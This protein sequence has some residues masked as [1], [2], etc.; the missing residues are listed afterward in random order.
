MKIIS[1]SSLDAA[2]WILFAVFTKVKKW[3]WQVLKI[4]SFS[5][6]ERSTELAVYYLA[7]ARYLHFDQIHTDFVYLLP[8]KKSD[9]TRRSGR[10]R[11]IRNRISRLS[12]SPLKKKKRILNSKGTNGIRRFTGADGEMRISWNEKKVKFEY[13]YG[14]N[15]MRCRLLRWI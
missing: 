14:N 15:C 6:K 11:S 8:T 2:V 5:L 3:M 10:E 4:E 13:P 9:H 12:I 7:S 1:L